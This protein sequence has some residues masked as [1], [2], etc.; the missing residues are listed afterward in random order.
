MLLSSAKEDTT[1]VNLLGEGTT[2]DIY[3]GY[4]AR[5]C[6]KIKSKIYQGFI[7]CDLGYIF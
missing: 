2:C 5:H 7:L 6:K 4:K 1:R 3:Y